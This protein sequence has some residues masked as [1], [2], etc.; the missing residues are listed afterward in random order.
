[1]P[2]SRFLKG[3]TVEKIRL[4][5]ITINYACAGEGPPVLLLHG[6]PQTHIVWR[7]IAPRLV[8][9]GY[10]VIAPDL[11]GYGDSEKPTSDAAHLTYSKR[12]MAQDQIALMAAL[13]H[14]RFSVI[15]HDRGG[16]VAHRLALDAPDAVDRLAVLDIAP[17]LTMYER[18]DQAFATRYF[19]WFFL[20]QPDGLPEKLIGGDPEYFPRRHIAG[21]VKTKGAVSEE[22][23]AEYLRSYRDPATIHAICEDYRASASIDLD[24]DRADGLKRISAPLLA[25]WGARSV[26]G[27]LYDVEATWKDKALDVTARALPCGHAIPEEAPEDLFE[28]LAAFLA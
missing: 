2:A 9:A 4:P 26:V 24:H 8:G 14:E 15:G 17:T 21:Q 23:M 3:F 12:A 11:R 1:M 16:R 10:R 28:L 18:T 27:D 5:G 25:V 22:A 7:K 6:H 19:W 13:G 20:I